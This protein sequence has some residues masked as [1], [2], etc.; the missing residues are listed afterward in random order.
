MTREQLAAELAERNRECGHIANGL[1]CTRP[2]GHDGNH[3]GQPITRY[4]PLN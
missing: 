4:L 3:R 2:R 1:I